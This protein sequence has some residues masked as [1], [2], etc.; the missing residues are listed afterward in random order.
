MTNVLSSPEDRAL[1]LMLGE[2]KSTSEVMA[3]MKSEG[4][5]FSLPQ[6]R[7]MKEKGFEALVQDYRL[8][9]TASFMLESIQ[10]VTIKFED[11]Y[12]RLEKLYNNVE[13]KGTTFEQITVLNQMKEML[14]MSLKKLGEYTK[15]IEKIQL[16][17][18]SI[19]NS[20]VMV[21]IKQNESR[22]FADMDPELKDGELIFHK[23][24]PE[25]LDAY[26]KYKFQHSKA[27]AIQ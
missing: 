26:Y 20:D 2:K 6:L 11:L 19:N 14:N 25:V 15:G 18:I 8:D 23:P 9:A 1:E 16:Q 7:R 4:H 22:W 5:T 27:Q 3:I 21:A 24:L 12:D 17:T 13:S 10:N